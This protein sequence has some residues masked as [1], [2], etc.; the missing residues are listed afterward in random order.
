M[1][2]GIRCRLYILNESIGIAYDPVSGLAACAPT[3]QRL[4]VVNINQSAQVDS[5]ADTLTVVP[6]EACAD[7]V[8]KQEKKKGLLARCRHRVID[9]GRYYS[10]ALNS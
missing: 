9:P 7:E 5:A 10:I 4:I 1:A 8:R 6:V 2:A 3:R